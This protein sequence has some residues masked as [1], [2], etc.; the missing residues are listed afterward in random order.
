MFTEKALASRQTP[1]NLA[2][3]FQNDKSFVP[4]IGHGAFISVTGNVY[5]YKHTMLAARA[6][7]ECMRKTLSENPS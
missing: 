5:V 6:F 4:R 3:S 1:H 7:D 2:G